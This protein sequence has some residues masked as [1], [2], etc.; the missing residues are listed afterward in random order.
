MAFSA[1]KAMM[2]ANAAKKAAKPA[3]ESKKEVDQEV[4]LDSA[5]PEAKA[6][7]VEEQKTPETPVEETKTNEDKDKAE[8]ESDGLGGFVD[9]A[10]EKDCGEK[11]DSEMLDGACGDKEKTTDNF[12]DSD[13]TESMADFALKQ[14][15]SVVM[16]ALLEWVIDSSSSFEELEALL[17][18]VAD[19]DDDGELTEE[20]SAVLDDIQEIAAEA[21]VF[22]GAD[23][24]EVEAMFEDQT[25][26]DVL[27]VLSSI[28][29]ELD[30]STLSD[31]DMINSFTFE[32]P[33]FMD[34][35]VR[36]VVNGVVKL[37]KKP[38]R[39]R[40]MSAQQKAALKKARKKAHSSAAR[41]ARKKS[42]RLRKSRGM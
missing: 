35:M 15:R 19:I 27:N 31:D 24:S 30:D 9:G 25:D 7:P 26:D 10:G 36:K 17:V 12:M 39:K 37:V 14:L 6:K 38:L 22:M 41:A 32:Q 21:L 16:A 1:T 4:F 8:S 3:P 20:E 40:K 33:V 34:A 29:S 28:E 5:E 42:M 2:K 13:G 23:A 11:H 18:G